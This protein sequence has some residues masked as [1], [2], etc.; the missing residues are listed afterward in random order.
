M[1]TLPPTPPADQPLIITYMTLRKC[2]GFMGISLV[3]VLVLGSLL[4][5]H[6]PQIRTSVSAYYFSSMRNEMEGIICGI[7]LFLL[8][9][10]GYTRLDSRVSKG[11]GFFALCIAFLP[12][13]PAGVND[14]LVSKLHYYTAGA[15]FALL[16][17]MSIFLFT[18]SDGSWTP[19]KKKR[20]KV[21]RVCGIIMAV[22]VLGIPIDGINGIYQH[23]SFLKPT[24]ILETFA[25]T[26]FGIS[27]LTKGEFILKD[28]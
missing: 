23:I 24:L 1:A 10:H 3:P 6:P 28:K 25:L 27:W 7:A 15:F 12:T 18:R 11:A 14:D 5:D 16:A 17:Y 26:S 20:N 8:S 9:Y 13:V 2:I 4:L 19:Q 21:Y 22:S